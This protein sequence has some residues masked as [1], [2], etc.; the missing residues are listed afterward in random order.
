MRYRLIQIQL[1]FLDRLLYKCH[2]L[3]SEFSDTD[4]PL[5]SVPSLPVDDVR[6][7]PIMR[8]NNKLKGKYFVKERNF[9]SWVNGWEKT[10]Q[11]KRT[12]TIC[13][14][15]DTWQKCN[16]YFWSQKHPQTSKQIPRIFGRGGEYLQRWR[17]GVKCTQGSW[18]AMEC[19]YVFSFRVKPVKWGSTVFHD[20]LHKMHEMLQ[21]ASV[22]WQTVRQV[23]T[24]CP[25][26]IGHFT[27]TLGRTHLRTVVNNG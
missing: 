13:W 25:P 16:S 4:M 22:D 8:L 14:N 21:A 9:T 26:A 15:Y 11:S 5:D 17:E 3:V 6:K 24:S 12:S 1:L 2:S 23:S 27:T 7:M 10:S 19:F 20:D 18:Q